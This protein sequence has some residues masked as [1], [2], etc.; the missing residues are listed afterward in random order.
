MVHLH[1]GDGFISH[2]MLRE[3]RAQGGLG[4]PGLGKSVDL[5]PPSPESRHGP[6]PG[7]Q[8]RSCPLQPGLPAM[9]CGLAGGWIRLARCPHPESSED[10]LATQHPSHIHQ[11]E[12]VVS[13]L[14]PAAPGPLHSSG[15]FWEAEAG[16]AAALPGS[17]YTLHQNRR[18][19]PRGCQLYFSLRSTTSEYLSLA[20]SRPS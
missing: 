8:P 14:S 17:P 15:G 11:E 1:W 20:H 3:G 2:C 6:P 7:L 10:E 5:P 9:G 16:R 19:K 13:S 18:V 12:G 4:P